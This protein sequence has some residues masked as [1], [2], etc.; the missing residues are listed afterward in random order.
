MNSCHISDKINF[1][2]YTVQTTTVTFTHK[3]NKY[4]K[5][6]CQYNLKHPYLKS[7]FTVCYCLWL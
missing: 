2:V 6:T 3:R 5:Y 1:I 4:M 7:H